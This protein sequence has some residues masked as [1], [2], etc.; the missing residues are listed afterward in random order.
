M[1]CHHILHIKSHKLVSQSLT[2]FEGSA[3]LLYRDQRAVVDVRSPRGWLQSSTVCKNFSLWVHVL[4]VSEYKVYEN[5]CFENLETVMS[6]QPQ[7]GYT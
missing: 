4:M 2:Y 7:S 5:E 1:F 3:S 6:T